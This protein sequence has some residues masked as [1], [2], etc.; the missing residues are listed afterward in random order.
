MERRPQVNT[1]EEIAD[2]AEPALLDV[3]HTSFSPAAFSAMKA[4]VAQYIDDL[5]QESANASKRD[6]SDIIS[7]K[8][9]EIA[10]AHL[11]ESNGNK[12]YKQSGTLG[13]VF[14]GA[15]FSAVYPMITSR[16]VTVSGLIFTVTTGIVGAVLA[17]ISFMKE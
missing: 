7:A 15:C 11:K 1:K 5:V 12:I 14:L 3:D 10:S 17:M 6:R 8:H 16:Q 4:N 13:G 2:R 9:I